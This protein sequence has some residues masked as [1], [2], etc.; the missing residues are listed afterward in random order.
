MGRDKILGGRSQE[1]KGRRGQLSCL[2]E[3][4]IGA[5]PWS[6]LQP[7][8]GFW[9]GRARLLL[10]GQPCFAEVPWQWKHPAFYFPSP[11]PLPSA[12]GALRSLIE[13]VKRPITA[14]ASLPRDQSRPWAAA[15]ANN[16]P[17]GSARPSRG[18][19][20]PGGGERQSPSGQGSQG[21]QL[22]ELDGA[23]QLGC[24]H[25]WMQDQG[26]GDGDARVM[27]GTVGGWGSWGR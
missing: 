15:L 2:R 6:L 16:A 22:L 18:V 26:T 4:D 25:P 19:E 7:G 12:S 14:L 3:G 5:T 10:P 27:L 21:K 8:R 24:P 11:S 1:G 13:I 17:V 23:P 9:S 20:A